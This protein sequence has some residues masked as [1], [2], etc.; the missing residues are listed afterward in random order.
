MRNNRQHMGKWTR[1]DWILSRLSK[2][3]DQAALA[4]YMGIDAPQLNRTLLGNR[5]MRP[6]EVIKIA[7]YFSITTDEVHSGITEKKGILPSSKISLPEEI[8]RDVGLL[9]AI[10]IILAVMLA[11]E[12]TTE[13]DLENVISHQLKAFHRHNQPGAAE[14]MEQLLDALGLK[15]QESQISSIRKLLQL[16]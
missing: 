3:G 5:K 2:R 15:P 13:S 16:R 12:I 10:K 1:Y 9:G 11:K 8:E 4:K 6:E 7:K 14:I